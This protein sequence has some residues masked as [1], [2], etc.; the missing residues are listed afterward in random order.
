MP[1]SPNQRMKLLYLMKILL[2]KTDEQNPL[3][4]AELIAELAAYGVGAERKSVYS[5]L[6]LL[7]RFGIDVE[8]QRGKTTGYYAAS[9]TFELPE[10]KL[11]ADAVQSSRFITEKRSEELIGKLASLTS[12]AQAKQ[13]RRQV[14]VAGRA[15]GANETVYYS[16]DQIHYAINENRK[17][18][19]KYFDYDVN[20][21]RVYRKGGDLYIATPVTLCWN[22][23]CY[24]LIAYSAKHDGLAHYRVDRMSGASAS[25][26]Q[27]D[28]F[29]RKRLNVAGHIKRV[30]GMYSGEPVRAAL[31]F[32]GSLVNVVLDHF[33]K[34]ARLRGAAKKSPRVRKYAEIKIGGHRMWQE[35]SFS[36]FLKEKRRLREITVREMA[37]LAGV[38]PGYY[39]DI[40]SGRRNPPDRGILDRI[41][42]ALNASDGDRELFYDLAGRARSEAPPALP[43]SIN[44]Y[45]PVRAALRLAKDR[46][47]MDDWRRFI[48]ALEQKGEKDDG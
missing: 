48:R 2:E 17:I 18:A 27:G 37:E 14:L 28:A 45:E 16:I 43:D 33:G 3:T 1:T 38:S 21:R 25:E 10:L 5:D 15:K 6:E 19:F 31:A 35:T 42:T 30:F 44:E 29:D 7:R 41:I 4:A 24:Y 40:E 9:R 8:T 39:S 34:N 26:E 13:L 11:L 23:D 20:K 46:G 36:R 32:D 22:D 47:D 12:A